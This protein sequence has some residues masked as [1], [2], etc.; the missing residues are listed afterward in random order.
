MFNTIHKK[1]TKSSLKYFL[2]SSTD[3][4]TPLLLRSSAT[5]GYM[6]INLNLQVGLKRKG[7]DFRQNDSLLFRVNPEICM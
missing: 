4:F 1:E 5:K 2:I 6:I 7:I 3:N